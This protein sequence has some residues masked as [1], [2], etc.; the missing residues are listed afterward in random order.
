MYLEERLISCPG[1]QIA[2]HVSGVLPLSGFFSMPTLYQM[3]KVQMHS[4]KEVT[5]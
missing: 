1:L 4:I 5:D 3:N 2:T